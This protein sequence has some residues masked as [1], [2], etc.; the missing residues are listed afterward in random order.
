MDEFWFEVDT[1]QVPN[2][3][4]INVYHCRG[5]PIKARECVCEWIVLWCDV[6]YMIE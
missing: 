6:S 1:V 2:N 4:S 5:E 3:F